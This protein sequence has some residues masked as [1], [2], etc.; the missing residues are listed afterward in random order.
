MA[1]GLGN[2]AP[3]YICQAILGEVVT[4]FNNAN[5]YLGVGISTTAY[6]SSQTDLL[7]ASKLRKGMDATYPTRSSNVMT[8]RSTFTTAEANFAWE[9]NGIF[10]A[11]SAG[12]MLTRE[13]AALGTKPGT[14][15]W[16]LTIALTLS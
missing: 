8:F 13:N 3:A 9:E 7:G 16:V 1:V 10:N 2:A 14:Q 11:A 5:S 15:Q 4:A 6:A 12:T